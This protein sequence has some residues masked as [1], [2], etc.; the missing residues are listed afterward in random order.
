MIGMPEKIKN[1]GSI[2][3]PGFLQSING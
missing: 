3:E 2:K 1:P